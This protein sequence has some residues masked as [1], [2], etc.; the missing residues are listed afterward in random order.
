M[1]QACNIIDLI[2]LKQR[3]TTTELIM[4]LIDS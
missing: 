2:A 3:Y 4:I 1:E